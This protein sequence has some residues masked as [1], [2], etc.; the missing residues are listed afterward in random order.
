[1]IIL[2]FI[3][4][5]FKILNAD[6]N[7]REIALGFVL[8]MWLGLTPVTTLYAAVIVLLFLVLRCNLTSVILA[9]AIFK[10]LSLLVFDRIS[11]PIG[12]YLLT[13][14]NMQEFWH[15][16]VN[17]PI[18]SFANLNDSMV[19]GG[20]VLGW[21]LAIPVYL[22]IRWTIIKYRSMVADEH[23]HKILRTVRR[24]WIVRVLKWVFMGPTRA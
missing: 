15:K 21:I 16:L 6:V 8:G 12:Y 11:E 4:R 10:P 14:E 17:A 3:R 2:K 19:L 23:R 20:I 18:L 24:F 5:V 13:R 9:F 1:M 7:P 22:L